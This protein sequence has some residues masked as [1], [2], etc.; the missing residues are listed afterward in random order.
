MIHAVA[1]D[2]KDKRKGLHIRKRIQSLSKFHL[3]TE[4]M[5]MNV[6]NQV[7]LARFALIYSLTFSFSLSLPKIKIKKGGQTER[8]VLHPQPVFQ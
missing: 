4:G 7:S 3:I 5:Q 8:F 6:I 1:L 2:T